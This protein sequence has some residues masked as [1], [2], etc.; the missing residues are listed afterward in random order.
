MN[1]SGIL[2]PKRFSA[3]NLSQLTSC[4]GPGTPTILAQICSRAWAC[5]K[6][7]GPIPLSLHLL[8]QSGR[9]ETAMLSL[10]N[11]LLQIFAKLGIH[12]QREKT[13]SW[14]TAVLTNCCRGSSADLPHNR[15]WLMRQTL[16]WE[17]SSWK[18]FC[19]LSNR[20][21]KLTRKY[22]K[23]RRTRS[24]IFKIKLLAWWEM[25]TKNSLRWTI[26]VRRETTWRDSNLKNSLTHLVNRSWWRR[27][28]LKLMSLS[29]CCIALYK[30]S[31]MPT[32]R[33]SRRFIALRRGIGPR[34]PQRKIRHQGR[35]RP[36]IRSS[37]AEWLGATEG[38]WN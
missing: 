29:N 9:T 4:R 2:S 20:K 37:R 10:Q 3:R 19:Q 5:D 1:S 14:P 33:W 21:F 35:P 6:F 24:S 27:I 15:P 36:R 12:S 7:R 28:G 18:T 31:R 17:Q 11:H 16:K 8:N 26:K 22:S 38:N 23:H 32:M 25:T 34:I 30:K 13:P